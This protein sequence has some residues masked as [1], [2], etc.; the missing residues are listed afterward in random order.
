MTGWILL[1]GPKASGRHQ[2][3]RALPAMVETRELAQAANAP[4]GSPGVRR[5]VGHR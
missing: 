5:A 2:A 4:P 1:A 3:D